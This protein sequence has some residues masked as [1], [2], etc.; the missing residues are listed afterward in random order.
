MQKVFET[1]AFHAN[2]ETKKVFITLFFH[3]A[4]IA[5]KKLYSTIII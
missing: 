1:L 4:Q 2:A 3:K 5:S